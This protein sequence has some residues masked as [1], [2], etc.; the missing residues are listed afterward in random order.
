MSVSSVIDHHVLIT[1]YDQLA[2]FAHNE[3]SFKTREIK[4]MNPKKYKFVVYTFKGNRNAL[5]YKRRELNVLYTQWK[6][7]KA[8]TV[9]NVRRWN[10]KG[11]ILCYESKV[12]FQYK[13][14]ICQIDYIV[15]FI[16]EKVSKA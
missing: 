2:C 10:N 7:R 9:H 4:K 5:L 8:I 13:G 1:K 12:L 14:N 11:H 16:V 15:K 6:N 3:T